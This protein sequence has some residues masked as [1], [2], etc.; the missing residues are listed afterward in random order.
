MQNQPQVSELDLRDRLDD[1]LDAL[2]R[3]EAFA[4]TRNGRPIGELVP[5]NQYDFITPE[6]W[7]AFDDL[8][9]CGQPSAVA[10]WLMSTGADAWIPR[11]RWTAFLTE[12]GGSAGDK[13]VRE[14]IQQQVPVSW[15]GGPALAPLEEWPRAEDGTPLA[16]VLSLA[17][18][19]FQFEASDPEPRPRD[20]WDTPA[21]LL[22]EDGYL[23]LFHDIR[24]G[25]SASVLRWIPEPETL[26]LVEPPDDLELPSMVCQE[27]YPLRGWTLPSPLDLAHDEF[28]LGENLVMA[29]QLA[30][31]MQRR[32]VDELPQNTQPT[33][34]THV[35]GHGHADRAG[36]EQQLV[37]ALPLGADDAWILLF[38]I[39]SWTVF[40]DWWGDVPQVEVWIRRSDLV[41]R[42]FEEACVL[43]RFD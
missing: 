18:V 16:K 33:P 41:A 20:S 25:A 34:T 4:L 39:E 7:T 24:S 28:E 40:E 35:F 37:T 42:R 32:G 43:V 19:Q 1:I 17:L 9:M 27:V 3:G 10:E 23:E 8:P 14:S 2:E 30:W 11:V 12:Q 21:G 26:E 5:T 38:D 15:F 36:A 29:L 13:G 6:L 31:L 22:P